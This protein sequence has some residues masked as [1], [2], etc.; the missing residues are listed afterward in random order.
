MND[1][2]KPEPTA[3]GLAGYSILIGYELCSRAQALG[4]KLSKLE[5]AMQ[6]DL[7]CGRTPT[8]KEHAREDIA[9]EYRAV[10]EIIRIYRVKNHPD[11]DG[12][13]ESLR[14]LAPYLNREKKS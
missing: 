9:N 7:S 14:N 1:P 3:E 6:L 12:I 5:R 10:Q 13:E 2:Q 11:L 4:R 8:I